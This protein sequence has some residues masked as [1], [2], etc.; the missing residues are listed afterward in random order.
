MDNDTYILIKRRINMKTMENFELTKRELS[1]LRFHGGFHR[2]IHNLEKRIEKRSKANNQLLLEQAKDQLELMKL[3]E[4][5]VN[6][7]LYP[8]G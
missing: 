8:N 2:A 6:N 7:F 4:Q 5:R 1:L 3:L